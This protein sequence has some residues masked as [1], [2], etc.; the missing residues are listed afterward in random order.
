MATRKVK[1]LKAITPP[2]FFYTVTVDDPRTG[3]PVNVQ[4]MNI[5]K[6]GH[7]IEIDEDDMCARYKVEPGYIDRCIK[8]G[9]FA[10][11]SAHDRV[12]DGKRATHGE[13]K[14][15]ASGEEKQNPVPA[16]ADKDN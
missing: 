7:I 13:Y 5:C 8:A 4:E 1:V 14:D 9:I 3:R 2:G 10:P 12:T 11:A 6:P 16:K 15:A